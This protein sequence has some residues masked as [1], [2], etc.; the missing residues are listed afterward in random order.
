MFE[1]IL[2]PTDGSDDAENAAATAIE[3][4]DV[5]DATVH[6]VSVADTGPWGDVRLPGEADDPSD[7]I[8][9]LAEDAVARVVERAEAANVDVTGTVLTG[10]VKNEIV[11]HAAA[12]DAD[13]IVMGTRGRGGVKRMALG[14]VAD[15]VVRNGDPEVLV[16]RAETDD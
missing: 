7:A 11:D 6:V 5:H 9:G 12:I 1:T 3:L 4:A 8:T 10:P 13:L 15:F 2:V 14:S 16:C